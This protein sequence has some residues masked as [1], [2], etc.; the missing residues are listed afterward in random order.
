[1]D[2][3]IKPLVS[4]V[5]ISYQSEKYILDTLESIKEQTWGNIELIISDDAST[6]NTVM[7]C[8]DWIKK[9]ENRFTK[10]ILLTTPFNTGIPANCN[11]GLQSSKGKWIKF[12]G[13]DDMLLSSCIKDNM[14]VI[15]TSPDI[16]LVISNL[17]EVNQEGVVLRSSPENE[18]L[19]YFMNN[20]NSKEQKLKAYSRWPAFLNTPTFFYNRKLIEEVYAPVI[21]LKIFEDTSTVFHII[22]KGAKI[23]YLNKPTV[24]Y[25]I[26]SGAISRDIKFLEEREKESY[27]IY[28]LYRKKHL[29]PFNPID[30]SVYYESWLRFK[31]KGFMGYRGHKVL[32][33]FS[34]FYWQLRIK[35]FKV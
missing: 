27:Y 29:S 13:A 22:E 7:I 34:L 19:R 4:V 20:Q 3:Q 32:R 21:D 12:I 33:L 14:E 10:S 17:I 15:N 5:V 31:Y 26:H 2:D 30:I 18:G 9:N 16:S 11:R 24:K 6:D 23:F 25:R 8:R 35:G 28:K 1:M